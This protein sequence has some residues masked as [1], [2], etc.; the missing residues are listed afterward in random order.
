M[1]QLYSTVAQ[2]SFTIVGLFF[3]ALTV[4]S[5]TRNF[6]FG[7]KPQ[8]RYAYLNLLDMLFP[9]LLSLGA[10][11]SSGEGKIP[12]WPFVSFFFFLLLIWVFIELRRLRASPGYHIIA[13]FESILDVRKSTLLEI[14]Y[15]FFLFFFGIISVFSNNIAFQ[16][17]MNFLFAIFLFFSISSSVIPVMVFL[18][19]YTENKRK[20]EPE[21]SNLLIKKGTPKSNRGIFSLSI[22]L[23]ALIAFLF[24]QL[25]R[26]K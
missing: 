19:V 11:L 2:I 14:C 18:R 8:N 17:G 4:D 24:G 5:E 15:L 16:T 21:I 9:G 13:E 7:Q 20:K 3:V 10:L 6:W 26:K 12:S 25:L 22:L 1:E 23:T